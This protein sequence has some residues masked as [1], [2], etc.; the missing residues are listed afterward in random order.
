MDSPFWQHKTL[1]QLSD[2]EWESLCD[3]C[4]KCC[5]NKIE[6]EDSGELFFTN[7]ACRLLDI[8]SCRCTDYLQRTRKVP[9]CLDLRARFTAFHW[10][11][12]TCAY[13]CLSEGRELPAWHPLLTGDRA[14]VHRAGE[15]VRSYAVSEEEIVELTDHVIEWLV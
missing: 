11:P 10:L 4:A 13:R 9:E 6:D 1:D 8:E 15:S 7:A 5:L 12:T 3:G 14:S 2:P